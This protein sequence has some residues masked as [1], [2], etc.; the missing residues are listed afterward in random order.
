MAELVSIS[1][2]VNT[3]NSTL[4]SVIDS[5]NSK[6]YINIKNNSLNSYLNEVLNTRNIDSTTKVYSIRQTLD[7]PLLIDEN[8]KKYINVNNR[9][10]NNITDTTNKSLK[11]SYIDNAG[12]LETDEVNKKKS[13]RQT[14]LND[15]VGLNTKTSGKLYFDK[16]FKVQ[17]TKPDYFDPVILNDTTTRMHY[18][19]SLAFEIAK[20]LYT[21]V[22]FNKV[23][24]NRDWAK[25]CINRAV[26]FAEVYLTYVVKGLDSS[27]KN[28]EWEKPAP[29]ISEPDTK[30]LEDI[31]Q[32][33]N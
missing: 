5:E 33:G 9:S 24:S 31:V 8:N 28:V 7:E 14:I 16:A 18:V 23:K 15:T 29:V 25:E 19:R 1:G 13:I 6:N 21:Y 3:S 30:E 17:L 32:G 20:D 22:D 26:D 11:V 12:I 4:E 2:T 10:I 27:Y